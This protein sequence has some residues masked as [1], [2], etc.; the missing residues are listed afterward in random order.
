MINLITGLPGAAKTLYTIFMVRALSAKENRPVFYSGISGLDKETL[1]WQEVDAEKW[2]EC[3]TG[4]IVIIDECQRVFRPRTIARDVPEY[5]SKLETHR[6]QGIDL[7]LIT[8]H[9]MLADSAIRRLTGNHQHIVRRF[10][11]QSSTIHQWDSVRDQPEKSSTRASSTK[12]VWSFDKSIFNLYKSAEIHTVKRKLPKRLIII[13]LGPFAVALA[14]YMVYRFVHKAS[15]PV[16]ESHPI[17]GSAPGQFGSGSGGDRRVSYKNA[18]DDVKQYVYE[19]TPRIAE[20][21]YSAPKYDKI[22]EPTVAPFPVGCIKTAHI[23][24]CYSQQATPIK[25]TQEMCERIISDGVFEDFDVNGK[26]RA[27]SQQ[28]QASSASAS[29][30]VYTSQ[31]IAVAAAPDVPAKPPEDLPFHN[32]TK[33]P[34]KGKS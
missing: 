16:A 11:M 31:N 24:Q 22:T 19:Q 6:H 21:P 1:G 20:L 13:I 23:C 17:T 34:V 26:S 14:V 10:G 7:F 5:V 32:Y 30:A 8:Q 4:S 28:L 27:D 33:P 29:P 9:P 3:P 12:T 15:S 18:E 25:T 2:Y